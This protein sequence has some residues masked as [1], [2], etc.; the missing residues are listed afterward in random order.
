VEA[1]WREASRGTAPESC[2]G[3]S[4]SDSYRVRRLYAH[5]LESGVLTRR[6]AA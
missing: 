1:V 5:W 4:G 6:P 3:L 2:E